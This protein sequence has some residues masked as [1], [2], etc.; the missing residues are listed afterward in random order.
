MYPKKCR[1]PLV[2]YRKMLITTINQEYEHFL[3][4]LLP[5]QNV[6]VILIF[7]VKV[8]MKGFCTLTP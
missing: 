5:R 7:G 6:A 1:Y 8:S 2:I 3:Q 4:T